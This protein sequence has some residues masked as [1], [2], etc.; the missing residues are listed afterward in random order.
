MRHLENVRLLEIRQVLVDRTAR[1]GVSVQ[2]LGRGAVLLDNL[3][4]HY[5]AGAAIAVPAVPFA[6][7]AP[8]A[9]APVTGAPVTVASVLASPTG[10]VA[11][12]APTM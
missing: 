8:V 7:V 3:L 6:A 5:V 1:H 12:L 2:L 9:V 10:A 4:D 11:A